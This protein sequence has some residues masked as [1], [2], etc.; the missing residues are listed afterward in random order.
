MYGRRGII[1]YARYTGWCCSATILGSAVEQILYAYTTTACV[2]IA[3]QPIK[4][5]LL[6]TNQRAEVRQL[7]L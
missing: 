3:V 4:N 6:S 5:N 2:L 7:S 1:T